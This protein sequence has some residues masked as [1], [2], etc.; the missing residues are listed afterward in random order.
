MLQH[1][2]FWSLI[3]TNSLHLMGLPRETRAGTALLSIQKETQESITIS[4]VG[5]YV[6]SMK[7]K[8][9]LLRMKFMYSL[10][11]QPEGKT[12]KIVAKL[13]KLLSLNVCFLVLGINPTKLRVYA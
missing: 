8:M 3:E 11:Y 1:G 2:H 12:T 6:C 13:C 7:K 4:I 10:L 5:K 9:C